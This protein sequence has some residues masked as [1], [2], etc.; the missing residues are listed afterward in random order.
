[1]VGRTAQVACRRLGEWILG[2][3]GATSTRDGVGRDGQP[4]L[5]RGGWTGSKDLDEGG[6]GREPEDQ[7]DGQEGEL[8]GI[9]AARMS[10]T[11]ASCVWALPV[12]QRLLDSGHRQ[13]HQTPT[14]TLTALHGAGG[15]W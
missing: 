11:V 2:E 3:G 6:A 8:A 14:L 15:G 10:R 4:D 7:A 5:A 13:L 12:G 9:H 1:M